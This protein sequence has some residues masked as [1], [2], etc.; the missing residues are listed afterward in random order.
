VR[1]SATP[2][3]EMILAVSDNGCGPPSG[4]N[5]STPSGLGF[6]LRLVQTLGRQIGAKID[7]RT[8]EPGM[9]I[10]IRMPHTPQNAEPPLAEPPARSEKVAR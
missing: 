8:A 10:E 2:D 3:G 5:L 9:T 1:C 6:G 4:F 7:I